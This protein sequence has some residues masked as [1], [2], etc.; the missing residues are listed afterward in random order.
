MCEEENAKSDDVGEVLRTIRNFHP[1]VIAFA[2]ALSFFFG[3]V[4]RSNLSLVTKLTVLGSGLLFQFLAVSFEAYRLD[5]EER[6][7][8]RVFK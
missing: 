7:R 5:R 4:Y 2:V 8:M 1:F 6:Q 3:I